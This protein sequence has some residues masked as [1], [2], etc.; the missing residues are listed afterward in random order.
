MDRVLV[1]RL[2]RQ[3]LEEFPDRFPASQDALR[4]AELTMT[5]ANKARVE[6][7]HSVVELS[8]LMMRFGNDLERFV[9]AD[10]ADAIL[11][12]DSLP[13]DLKIEFLRQRLEPRIDTGDEE[14]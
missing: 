14:A 10:W 2:T 12:H 7:D 8:R 5:K 9:D 6:S 11:S 3:L 4:Q 13:G 1:E